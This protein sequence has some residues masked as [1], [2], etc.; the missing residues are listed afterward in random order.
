MLC[1]LLNLH[2]KY[3]IL[4]YMFGQPNC[5]EVSPA[6]FLQQYLVIIEYFPNERRVLA[7]RALVN[8]AF[9][10]RVHALRLVQLRCWRPGHGAKGRL[11]FLDFFLKFL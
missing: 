7:A 11:V 4:V 2:G 9:L 3:L 8:F 6:Y 1:R 5:T 10:V